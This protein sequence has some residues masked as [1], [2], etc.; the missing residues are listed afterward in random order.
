MVIDDD[1][2]T[3]ELLAEKVI[4][5]YFT[6]QTYIEAMGRSNQFGSIKTIMKLIESETA[7]GQAK[8]K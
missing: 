4:E 8:T 7:A 5:L 6:R 2:L 3:P 1:L